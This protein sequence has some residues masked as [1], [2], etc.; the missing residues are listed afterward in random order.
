MNYIGSILLKYDF[1]LI[2]L[3]FGQ[4]NPALNPGVLGHNQKVPGMQLVK[5][6]PV[7]QGVAALTQQKQH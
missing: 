2:V 7:T 3:P 5:C 4:V 1:F 6:P